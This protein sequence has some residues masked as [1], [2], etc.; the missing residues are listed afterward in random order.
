MKRPTWSLREGDEEVKKRIKQIYIFLNKLPNISVWKQN[1]VKR[2]RL[3][4]NYLE[5]GGGGV[6]EN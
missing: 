2:Y 5:E 1:V 6:L 4:N 3:C